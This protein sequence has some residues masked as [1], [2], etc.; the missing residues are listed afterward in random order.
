MPSLSIAATRLPA[1][2]AAE[3]FPGTGDLL[4]LETELAKVRLLP[5]T[6]SPHPRLVAW[7]KPDEMEAEQFRRLAVRLQGLRA[8]REIKLLVITSGAPREGKSLIAANLAMIMSRLSR[9]RVLLLEGDLHRPTLMRRLK[10]SEK[11]PGLG[12]WLEKQ[13][14][15][16][17]CMMRHPTESL[18]VLPAGQVQRPPLELLEQARLSNWA[19]QLK[20]HF[21]WVLVDAPPLLPLADANH[22]TAIA[23]SVLLV[24]RQHMTRRSELRQVL[25]LVDSRMLIGVVLNDSSGPEHR[26]YSQYY[27]SRRSKD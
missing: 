10:L 2:E 23:D 21:D 8:Q 22:W 13:C 7:T 17:D 24:V 18:W 5:E 19:R 12:N 26:Y 27:Y 11:A 15:F 14:P 20:Q 16:S 9:E 25:E 1:P 3:P 6:M 4:E